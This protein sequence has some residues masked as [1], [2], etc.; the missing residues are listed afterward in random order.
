MNYDE[1]LEKKRKYDEARW[2]KRLVFAYKSYKKYR[3]FKRFKVFIPEWDKKIE[4]EQKQVMA[5]FKLR[6]QY[7]KNYQVVE[8]EVEG[9]IDQYDQMADWLDAK[10]RIEVNNIPNELLVKDNAGGKK[11]NYYERKETTPKSYA[12]NKDTY[13]KGGSSPNAYG[14]PFGSPKQWGVI[15]K[16]E[17]RLFEEQGLTPDEINS[18]D[19]LKEVIGLLF[20]N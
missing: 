10:L 8:L 14:K 17:K 12:N 3:R 7:S 5:E 20:N 16:N 15:Q 1:L 11:P 19:Q 4:E 2:N 6:K 13:N 9:T 18:Q